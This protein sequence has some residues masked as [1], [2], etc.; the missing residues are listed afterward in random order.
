MDKD[1]DLTRI[2]DRLVEALEYLRQGRDLL[3]GPCHTALALAQG[4]ILYALEEVNRLQQ[5]EMDRQPDHA[6]KQPED[7]PRG[8]DSAA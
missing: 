4:R 8:K 7:R 5:N 3:G 6:E 1:V 2:E